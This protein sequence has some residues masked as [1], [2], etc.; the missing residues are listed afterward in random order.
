MKPKI[1]T[2]F[3]EMS[4]GQIANGKLKHLRA[5]RVREI[6]GIMEHMLQGFEIE[7]EREQTTRAEARYSMVRLAN[8]IQKHAG[9]LVEICATFVPTQKDLIAGRVNAPDTG[10][11][12]NK[13]DGAAGEL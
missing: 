10:T 7:F 1:N 4:I 8:K 2:P 13:N 5:A 9:D 3:G 6:I 11:K 12:S